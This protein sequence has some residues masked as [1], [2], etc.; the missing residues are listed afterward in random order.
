MQAG[1][2]PDFGIAQTVR[3]KPDLLEIDRQAEA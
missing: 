3:L 2:E 1:L